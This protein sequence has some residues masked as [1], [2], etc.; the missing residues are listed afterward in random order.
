MPAMG[1]AAP[2]LLNEPAQ[3]PASAAAGLLE[4]AM[5]AMGAGL[6]TQIP[7]QADTRNRTMDNRVAIETGS[8]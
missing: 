3:A 5:P 4:R 6:P 1:L 2:L 7:S 8:T